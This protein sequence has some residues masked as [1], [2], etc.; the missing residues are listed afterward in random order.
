MHDTGSMEI[1]GFGTVDV[2]NVLKVGK[3]VLHEISRSVPDDVDLIG[4][5]IKGVVDRDR[6]V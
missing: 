1:E 4:K 3:C 6:R 5:S 2:T